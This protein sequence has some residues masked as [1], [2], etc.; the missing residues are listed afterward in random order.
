MVDGGREGE[1]DGEREMMD[2]WMMDRQ[3]DGQIGMMDGQ[4]V[5]LIDSY[6]DDR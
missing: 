2:G 6:T 5:T 1:R 4:L 3:I